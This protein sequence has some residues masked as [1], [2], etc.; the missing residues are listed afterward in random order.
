MFADW[1]RNISSFLLLV[2]PTVLSFSNYIMEYIY[3]FFTVKEA[4]VKYNYASKFR[5]FVSTFFKKKKTPLLFL[6][7][8]IF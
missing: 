6:H 5:F 1:A 7:N 4:S 8:N 2:V 3:L